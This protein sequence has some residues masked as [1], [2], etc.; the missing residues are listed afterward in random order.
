Y[1][2]EKMII[3]QP[4][5]LLTLA[6]SCKYL[7]PGQ[8]RGLS[9]AT[10]AA[11]EHLGGLPPTAVIACSAILLP[12]VD[13]SCRARIF[14]SL[15][16]SLVGQDILIG[17]VLRLCRSICD[18]QPFVDNSVAGAV[19]LGQTLRSRMVGNTTPSAILSAAMILTGEVKVERGSCALEFGDVADVCRL[20][21]ACNSLAGE[22]VH[23]LIQRVSD[24]SW[25]KNLSG[26]LRQAWALQ[27]FT[28]A[29]RYLRAAGEA[30][31][32]SASVVDTTIDLTVLQEVMVRK[33]PTLHCYVSALLFC[34]ARLETVERL[35]GGDYDTLTSAIAELLDRLSRYKGQL[36]SETDAKILKRCVEALKVEHREWYEEAIPV[37][38][39]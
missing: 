12:R 20:L 26:S 37:S 11:F 16:G 27:D 19:E 22:T 14:E 35:D 8:R 5:D 15:P 1:A 39:R 25:S 6:K 28:L 3:D 31:S 2:M 34:V 9:R 33:S 30:L 10:A 36:S 7:G 24:R 29:S 32:R 17:P 13:L 18:L 23:W 38:V 4:I 21:E